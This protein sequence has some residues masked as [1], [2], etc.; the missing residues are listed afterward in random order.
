MKTSNTYFS[1]NITESI[2]Y[3]N[4]GK[5]MFNWRYLFRDYLFIREI[6]RN[7]TKVDSLKKVNPLSKLAIF[8]VKN[9]CKL[10]LY[11][12]RFITGL[13]HH[14]M[15]WNMLSIDESGLSKTQ[16]VLFSVV[17]GGGEEGINPRKITLIIPAKR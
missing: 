13:K 4:Q 17:R 2:M 12:Q 14:Y 5:Q 11:W 8:F 7:W 6:R 15:G 16:S 10:Q 1:L 3:A 9:S